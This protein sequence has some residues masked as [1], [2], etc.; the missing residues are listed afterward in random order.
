MAVYGGG[1]GEHLS[2]L[3]AIHAI[4]LGT[5]AVE[6]IMNGSDLALQAI[7]GT[8]TQNRGAGNAGGEN[9]GIIHGD[10]LGLI[11]TDEAGVPVVYLVPVF[12][13]GVAVQADDMD[14]FA[15]FYIATELGTVIKQIGAGGGIHLGIRSDIGIEVGGEK[16]AFVCVGLLT[17]A[18]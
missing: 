3:V 9:I 17:E 18:D 11:G 6:L 10:D 15:G 14:A 2:H 7:T 1:G 4:N 12:A 5:Q 16:F 8:A 13:L